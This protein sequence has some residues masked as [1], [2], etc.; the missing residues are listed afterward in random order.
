MN[1]II[2]N[3]YYS[4]DNLFVDMNNLVM[5]SFEKYYLKYRTNG[6]FNDTTK[7]MLELF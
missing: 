6:S 2:R 5:K 7:I 1:D 4:H 3:F